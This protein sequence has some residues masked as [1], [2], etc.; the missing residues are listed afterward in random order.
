MRGAGSER[1]IHSPGLSHCF[2]FCRRSSGVLLALSLLAIERFSFSLA[3]A[4]SK[5]V[6]FPCLLAE[7]ALPLLHR[8]ARRRVSAKSGEKESVVLCPE[9]K[10]RQ[11]R[12]SSANSFF[13][14]FSLS[15]PASLAAPTCEPEPRADHGGQ[16]EEIARLFCP[17]TDLEID[18]EGVSAHP[19]RLRPPPLGTLVL[20]FLATIPSAA[21]RRRLERQQLTKQRSSKSSTTTTNSSKPPPWPS[22]RL[23]RS[24]R[25]RGRNRPGQRDGPR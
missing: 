9:K 11:A 23:R 1:K 17:A 5:T 12:W 25:R 21:R 24:P 6:S 2:F 13:R 16:E 8:H 19:K 22:T 18:Q 14:F 10:E 20:F 4:S 3:L 7:C 15:S